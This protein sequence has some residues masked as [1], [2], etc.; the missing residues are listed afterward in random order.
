MHCN[1][2]I[3]AIEKLYLTDQSDL[4]FVQIFATGSQCAW[5][6]GLNKLKFY[7]ET[8]IIRIHVTY[9]FFFYIYSFFLS[10]QNTSCD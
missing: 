5:N 4:L 10:Q 6:V 7:T 1:L 9:N 3:I 8:I 2:V